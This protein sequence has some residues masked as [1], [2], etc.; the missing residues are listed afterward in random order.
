VTKKNFL[1]FYIPLT[2]FLIIFF[3]FSFLNRAYIQGR[4]KALVDEQLLATAG[5]LKVHFSR[6]LEAE[7]A[8][9]E[10]FALFPEEEDI[11]YMALLD[12]SGKLLGWRSRFE[13]YLP[14][15]D[16]MIGERRSWIIESPV[17]RIFNAITSFSLSGEKKYYLYLGYSLKNLEEMMAHSRNNF[18]LILALIFGVGVLFSIG[19]YRFQLNYVEKKRE[20]DEEKKEKK[21]YQEISALTSGV[22]HE[23]KNPLN[24]LALLFEWLHK[25]AAPGTGEKI[26]YG[27]EEIRKISKIVD[28]FSTALKPIDLHKE[29]FSLTEI[30][31]EARSSIDISSREKDVNIRFPQN[32]DIVMSA[33]KG[34]IRQAVLNLI[35]N[36][37]E[38]SGRGEVKIRA[39]KVKG[40]T[41][42][43]I[44]DFGRGMTEDEKKH[45][46]EPF[47]ST[48][49]SGMGIGLYI[50]K[51]I[52]DAHQGKIRV[53]SEW[54]KGTTV[55]V[56]I[57]GG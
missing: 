33:D 3:V 18:Y 46:F 25:R 40:R 7:Y 56:E 44:Q 42:L 21:R 29:T 38:A 36:A 13:G 4:V 47:F 35:S 22:A 50:V 23:I 19:L 54:G 15:T 26:A 17:G 16:E 49:T 57:P 28:Q 9:D 39:E 48:K 37:T 32:D 2:G 51:K 31:S 24:S 1:F 52:I 30:I 10:I 8:P 14:L 45:I 34:L 55:I 27:K 11:Y 41:V 20:L 12:E 43:S 53:E 6:L 5:I